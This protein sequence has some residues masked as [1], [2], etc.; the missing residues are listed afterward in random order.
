L[1][2]TNLWRNYFDIVILPPAEVRDHSIALSKQLEAYGGKFV[3]GT[4]RFLPHISLYHI[5]VRPDLFLQFAKTVEDVAGRNPGGTLRLVSV[6]MPVLMTDKPGWLSRLHLEIV[7]STKEFLDR[8]Y[9]VDDMWRTDYLP[10]ELADAARQ[11]L[12][13]F[14]SPLIDAVFR[15]HITLTSFGDHA[16]AQRIPPLS[17]APLSFVTDSISIC[18][19]GPSH[20]CQNI[21]ETY[22]LAQR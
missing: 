10:A 19:L 9:G 13:E 11:N 17:F 12:E 2:E 20:S 15:P 1:S 14:G 18:E 5:P 21:V 7:E 8:S 16:T 22:P 6:E 3:L 4:S